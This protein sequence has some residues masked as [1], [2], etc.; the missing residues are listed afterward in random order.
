MAKQ[1]VDAK[2]AFTDA[3]SVYGGYFADGWLTMMA[4]GLVH[5][6]DKGVPALGYWVSVFV[7]FV[8]SQI[9]RSASTAAIFH[10]V[11]SLTPNYAKKVTV[12]ADA[13]KIDGKALADA[14]ARDIRRRS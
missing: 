8:V 3:L 11:K 4:F 12:K 7:A 10:R 6:E 9:T 13:M 1:D 14:L 2:V 5:S